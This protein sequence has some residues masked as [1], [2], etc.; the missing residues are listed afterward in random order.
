MSDWNEYALLVIDAQHDFWPDEVARTAPGMPTAMAGLLKTCRAEGIEV[1]HVHARFQPDMS[2]WMARYRLRGRIPCVVGTP[3]VEPLDFAAAEPGETVLVKQTFDA[4]LRTDLD[5]LLRA[6]GKRF[7]FVAGLVTSTCVL[8]TAASATQ[9]GYL[10]AVVEDCC[11][12]QGDAH[13][14]TLRA[15]PF[16]FSTTESLRLRD[17]RD[18]WE[19]QL[20]KL[21]TG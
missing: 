1:I 11:A 2:D 16:V 5:A 15:Y 21:G 4:F 7:L 14:R 3:G 9:L 6:R 10:V 18:Q 17:E 20:A 19:A 12:D 8:F 13:E